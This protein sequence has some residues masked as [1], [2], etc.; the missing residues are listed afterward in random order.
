MIVRR[1]LVRLLSCVAC[2]ALAAAATPPAFA[3]AKRPAAAKKDRMMSQK[4]SENLA[5]AGLVA[6][7]AEAEIA[8]PAAE[9]RTIDPNLLLVVDTNKGRI[10]A[11]LNPELAP[12]TVER[13]Q[14]LARQHFYDGLTFFRVIPDFMD[15]TGDPE[16]TGAGGSKLP[17]V[18]GEFEFRRTAKNHFATVGDGDGQAYGYVGPSPAYSQP[19]DL[20]GMTKD[21]GVSAWGA[22][23]PGVLGMARESEP[24]TGNSQFFFMREAYPSL[25]RKY[26]AFGKV[27]IGQ[28]VVRAIKIGEP[29]ASPQD[30]MTRVRLASDLPAGETLTV[31]RQDPAGPAFAT[32][33]A[34]LREKQ[35]AAISVC[36]VAPRVAGA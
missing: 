25:E 35:G 30:K 2:F 15:Q 31:K 36:D 8:I 4:E 17:N 24:D 12:A 13:V 33:V 22:F 16:N 5:K 26:A 29:V 7:K 14:S 34:R 3:Q 21:G 10:V 18:K 27:L 6:G 20:M 19:S 11:E 1:P 9:W 32:M 23:C 28:D